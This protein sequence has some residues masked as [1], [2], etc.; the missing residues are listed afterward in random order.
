MISGP[1]WSGAAFTDAAEGD[2]RGDGQSRISVSSQ[3]G[4]GPAWATVRQVHGREVVR[5][6]GPEAMGE[7][8]AILTDVPGLPLAV[9]T[10]DCFG[11]V[12]ISE[13]VVGVAHAGWRGAASSVVSALRE[14]MTRLGA[15]PD[16]AA[17]GPGIGP[18][19]FEVGS[20]VRRLFPDHLAVTSWGTD[21]VDLRGALRDQ[22]EGLDVWAD[23]RCTRHNED[24]LSHR[25]DGTRQ[26]MAAIGWL[27]PRPLPGHL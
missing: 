16:R 26:R 1:D 17:I 10:A 14:E 24:M 13:S 22:L 5:A 12:L 15:P 7:A 20:E 21:S 9:F 18:C 2:L 25:R 4:I 27:V 11:V 23:G 19:C 3:L 8:D 6:A